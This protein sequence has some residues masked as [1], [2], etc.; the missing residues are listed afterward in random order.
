MITPA[1]A[2]TVVGWQLSGRLAPQTFFQLKRYSLLSPLRRPTTV[3]QN[4]KCY[5]I[6]SG[7][8]LLAPLAD[9]SGCRFAQDTCGRCG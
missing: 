1:A 4:G 9:D 5:R 6:P 3:D 7:F 8:P 2:I